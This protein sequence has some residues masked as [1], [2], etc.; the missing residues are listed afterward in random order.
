[1]SKLSIII[2]HFNSSEKLKRLLLTIPNEKIEIIIIDD[3]SSNSEFTS[4]SNIIDEFKLRYSKVEIILKSNDG[5]KNAGTCRNKGLDLATGEFILFADADDYFCDNGFKEIFNYLNSQ[6]DIVYFPPISREE[7]SG[8]IGKRHL[9][10]KQLVESYYSNNN[11]TNEMNMKTGFVVPWSKLFRRGFLSVNNIR[12]DEVIVSNDIMFSMRTGCLAKS[13]H[14]SNKSVYCVVE[15][16]NSL[17]T[18]NITEERTSKRLDVA[19]NRIRY[20]KKTLSKEQ[21]KHTKISLDYW[22]KYL[23]KNKFTTVYKRNQLFRMRTV[24]PYSPVINLSLFAYTFMCM[25]TTKSK[26]NDKR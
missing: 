26:Y 9:Y 11:I 8:N 17:T 6:Y 13:F 5:Q 15:D 20:L 3:K 18:S 10:Y 24:L 25:L 19:I 7:V 2:P 23:V 16:N 22:V 4:L 21:L 14:V 1:M 12:F